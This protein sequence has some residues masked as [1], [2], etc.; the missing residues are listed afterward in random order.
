MRFHNVAVPQFENLFL[1]GEQT[2][3]SAAQAESLSERKDIRL[4]PLKCLVNDNPTF[5]D[6]V[7]RAWKMQVLDRDTRA[8]EGDF[9]WATRATRAFQTCGA[10][11]TLLATLG[12]NT[13][14]NLAK[15]LR[16]HMLKLKGKG[17]DYGITQAAL[18]IFDYEL[19]TLYYGYALEFKM[20]ECSERRVK[21]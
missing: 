21:E 5:E 2:I 8:W 11:F 10:E 16:A 15:G 6:Q 7:I 3:I 17:F 12:P 20:S 14:P 1:P 9:N 19:D 13:T 18:V 4:S